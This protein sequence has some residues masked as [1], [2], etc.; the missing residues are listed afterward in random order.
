[1]AWTATSLALHQLLT[2][3][4][5]RTGALVA[6]HKKFLVSRLADLCLLA[7][8]PLVHASVGSLNLDQIAAWA[9]AHP[10]LSPSM[11]VAAVLVVVAVA[12][13]SA[14]LPSTAG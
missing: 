6:A 10:G 11:H 1:M 13:K 8:L 5:D 4:P 12:L 2:F 3:Y 9:G 7:C 14:Q